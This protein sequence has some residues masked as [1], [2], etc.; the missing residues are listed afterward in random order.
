MKNI[1]TILL[2]LITNIVFSQTYP[3]NTLAGDVPDNAYIKDLNGELD[4]Y[5]GIWKGTWEG[6]TLILEFKKIKDYTAGNHPYYKDRILGERK[7][8]TAN[9]TVEI[10]RIT[11]FDNVNAEFYG[12]KTSLKNANQKQISF[13]PKNMCGKSATL[14]VNFLNP[15]KTQMSLH[16]KYDPSHLKEDCQYYNLI[17]QGG[18]LPIN[19]PKDITLIK[20]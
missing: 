8:V 16:F 14:D 19:F 9:G 15:E 11:N 5:I 20:Q 18:D 3:L 13:Y 1:I 2:L 6:K 17:T 12:I 10:D 4:P 7:V